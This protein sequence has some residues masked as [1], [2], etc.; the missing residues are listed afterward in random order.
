[1]DVDYQK[2]LKYKNKYLNLK[3]LLQVGGD[4]HCEKK[5]QEM[6]YQNGSPYGTILRN[7][8]IYDSLESMKILGTSIQGTQVFVQ[9]TKEKNGKKYHSCQNCGDPINKKPGGWIDYNDISCE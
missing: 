8:N 5:Q 9:M 1:M 2:Y 4:S 6:I 7:T 3:K